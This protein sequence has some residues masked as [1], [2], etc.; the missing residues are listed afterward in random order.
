M[1][2]RVNDSPARGLLPMKKLTVAYLVHVKKDLCIA[3]LNITHSNIREK[4]H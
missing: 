3:E 4:V 1:I 2:S